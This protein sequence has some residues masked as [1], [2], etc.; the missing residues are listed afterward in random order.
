MAKSRARSGN[1]LYGSIASAGGHCGAPG[2]F[3]RRRIAQAIYKRIRAVHPALAEG[4]RFVDMSDYE[5]E[6]LD[7]ERRLDAKLS[8]AGEVQ[9]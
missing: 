6:R 4:M 1:S 7:A 9:G 5:L 2:L 3:K 8:R